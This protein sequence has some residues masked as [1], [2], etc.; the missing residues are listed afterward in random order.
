MLSKAQKLAKSKLTRDWQTPEQL[1]VARDTLNAL[2]TK[3]VAEKQGN[4]YRRKT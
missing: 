3:Q 1:G 4:T 2:Y